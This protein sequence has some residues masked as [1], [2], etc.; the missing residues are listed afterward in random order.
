MRAL[1]A[2]C[3]AKITTRE[4]SE[5]S[6]ITEGAGPVVANLPNNGMVVLEMTSG[7]RIIVASRWKLNDPN[8]ANNSC[9][10]AG[11]VSSPNFPGSNLY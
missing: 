6:A 10:I 1:S 9:S 3:G 4:A 7:Q 8:P 5:D 2:S 11:Q